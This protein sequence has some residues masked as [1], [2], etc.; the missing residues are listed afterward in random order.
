MGRRNGLY[1]FRHNM[2]L[3]QEEM[4]KRIGCSRATYSSIECGTRDGRM[5]FWRKLQKAFSI[6]DDHIGELMKIDTENNEQAA[7][8]NRATCGNG[9]SI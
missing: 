5:S 9:R 3:S 2:R 7:K 1:M 8:N 4:A 6:G